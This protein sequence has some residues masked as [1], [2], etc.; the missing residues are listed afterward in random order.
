MAHKL[1]RLSKSL[2]EKPQLITPEKFKEIAEV[3]DHR[4]GGLAE[5]VKSAELANAAYGE[6]VGKAKAENRVGVLSV[7]GPLT[8]KA[9]GWEALCG[10]ASYDGLL[11]QMDQFCA[12]EDVSVVMMGLDSGGGEAYRCFETARQLRAKA[13]ASG[14]KLIGYIDGMAASAAYGLGSAC[15]ELILNP[16]GQAGSIGVVISLMNNSKQLKDK[17]IERKFITAG[18]SKVPFDDEGEFREGFLADLQESVDILYGEFVTHV[19]NMRGIPEE[20]VRGTEAKVFRSEKALELGLVDS[21]MEVEEF[22]NYLADLTESDQ[23]TES[24]KAVTIVQAHAETEQPLE[25][26]S[27]PEV[28]EVEENLINSDLED[29]PMAVTNETPTVDMA[30]FEEMQSRL[31]ALES[32]KSALEAEKLEKARKELSES[33]D[34]KTYLGESKESLVD[35]FMSTDVSTEH[36]TLLENVMA[37]AED[38]IVEKLATSQTEIAEMQ[39]KLEKATAKSEE[40]KEE[41]SEQ[42][43]EDVTPKAVASAQDSIEAKVASMKAQMNK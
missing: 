38:Y 23:K 8:A 34:S 7:E 9:S 35:F 37:S 41:F 24:K 30:A 13:D 20:T 15:H 11:S 29:I 4:N 26:L 6:D 33:L 25:K 3:L 17:G 42:V 10:G 22:Y 2:L 40:I 1:L 32:E 16:N 27:T 36:K 31:A 39:D 14:K 12:M 5:L 28:M 21:V 43:S 18:A 19:A